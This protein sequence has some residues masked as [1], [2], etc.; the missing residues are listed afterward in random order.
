[1]LKASDI[2][3][4]SV[5]TV[6]TETSVKELAGILTSNNISGA[7]VV[8]RKKKVIGVVTG[9]DLIFQNKQLHIPAVLAILDS[10]FFLESPD[11]M[12]QEM[13]KMAG[14]TVGDIFSK[15]IITVQ[16]DTTIA[17][18]AT[19]MSEQHLHTL[20]VLKD[21]I[22]VGVIGKKDI[23]KTIASEPTSEPTS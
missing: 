7:V 14:A 21:D 11:K 19:I 15:K 5:I 17:D 6:T 12:G 10:Y 20:P 2:M 23:I 13:Q 16:E 22:L 4:P 9:S 3:T 1:M 18:I 8:D